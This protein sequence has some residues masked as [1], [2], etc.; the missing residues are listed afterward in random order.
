M[1][2]KIKFKLT[3]ACFVLS[4]YLQAANPQKLTKQQSASQTLEKLCQDIQLVDSQKTAIRKYAEEYYSN[5]NDANSIQDVQLMIDK[6]NELNRVYVSKCDSLLTE[7][8]RET[9]KNKKQERKDK[10]ENKSTK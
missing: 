6:K 10:N 2:T 1:N 3:M 9:L 5:I 4:V 7:N 8:Q